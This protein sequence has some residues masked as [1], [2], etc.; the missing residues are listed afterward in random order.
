MTFPST[1]EF[2][3]GTGGSVV[4][5]KA[6]LVAQRLSQSVERF[7]TEIVVGVG[8]LVVI[9]FSRRTDAPLRRGPRLSSSRL[10]RH[11]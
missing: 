11:A 8:W 6:I 1:Y 5:L 7:A 10:L 4:V 3:F 2:A 9:F